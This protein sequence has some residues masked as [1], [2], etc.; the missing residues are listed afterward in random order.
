[1]AYLWFSNTVGAHK[2]PAHRLSHLLASVMCLPWFSSL[3]LPG[4]AQFVHF[5]KLLQTTQVEEENHFTS[6]Q[7][8]SKFRVT[9]VS[10]MMGNKFVDEVSSNTYTNKRWSDMSGIKLNK[11]NKMEREFLL[12]VDCRLYVSTKTYKAWVNLVKRLVLVKERDEQQWQYARR[13]ASGVPMLAQTPRYSA[14][15]VTAH[16]NKARSSSPLPYLKVPH[17]LTFIAPAS[18]NM[19]ADVP[20]MHGQSNSYLAARQVYENIML[21]PILGIY[22]RDITMGTSAFHAHSPGQSCDWSQSKLRR[23][24]FLTT[25]TVNFFISMPPPGSKRKA[26]QEINLTQLPAHSTMPKKTLTYNSTNSR[27]H[28]HRSRLGTCSLPV[29]PQPLS[30]TPNNEGSCSRLTEKGVEYR[31]QVEADKQRLACQCLGDEEIGEFLNNPNGNDSED[32]LERR[33]QEIEVHHPHNVVFGCSR[34]IVCVHFCNDGPYVLARGSMIRGW[35]KDNVVTKVVSHYN[36]KHGQQRRQ[37]EYNKTLAAQ[38]PEDDGYV[39][40][41]HYTNHASYRQSIVLEQWFP[42]KKKA[43]GIIYGASLNPIPESTIALV[44]TAVDYGVHQ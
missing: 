15:R 20:R 27:G 16:Q 34:F 10:L 42:K 7:P 37:I 13:H 41:V 14:S 17:S 26:L 3:R 1:M 4:S 8:G 44:F 21:L 24:L 29:V 2:S 43:D 12:G 11:I 31:L 18:S 36:P 23:F 35:V 5:M 25:T 22:S 38:L 6:G 32:E 30:V 28:K 19:F 40:E 9:V 39:Y 33:I